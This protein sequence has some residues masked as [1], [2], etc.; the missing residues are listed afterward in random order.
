M[1]FVIF[2]SIIKIF[3]SNKEIFISNKE[4]AFH[5]FSFLI[6]NNPIF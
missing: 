3:I 5:S 6:K 4:K 1:K 2:I